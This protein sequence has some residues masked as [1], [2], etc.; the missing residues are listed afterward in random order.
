MIMKRKTLCTFVV[1]IS[2]SLVFF[3]NACKKEQQH[4][5][6]SDPSIELSQKIL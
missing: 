6:K 3:L 1:L 4:P 2:I 5:S